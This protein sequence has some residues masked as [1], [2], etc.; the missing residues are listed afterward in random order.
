LVITGGRPDLSASHLPGDIMG[1]GSA[2][3]FGLFTIASKR[4]SSKYGL[5]TILIYTFLFGV[6]ELMPFY[7]LFTP[8][9]PPASLS[10]LSWSSI[11][12]L[13]VLCTVF[14]FFV[15][16]HGL[17]KLKASDVAMSIYV[18]PLSGIAL[19]ILLL[20]EPIT[21]CTVGGT[22]LIMAGL[23]MAQGEIAMEKPE[24]LPAATKLPARGE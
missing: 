22:A 15:Y 9:T 6:L 17:N 24:G 18:T 12:F 23:Y 5:V 16:T 4:V 20:G 11:L 7:V 13:A 3:S 1:V 19:A 14:A 21:A 2:I 8:M 10:V